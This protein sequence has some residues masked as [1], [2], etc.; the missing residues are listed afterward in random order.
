MRAPSESES[1]LG[2]LVTRTPSIQRLGLIGRLVTTTSTRT[3]LK[4]V[5]IHPLAR[6]GFTMLLI[7]LRSIPRYLP[8]RGLRGDSDPLCNGNTR[9]VL[10]GSQRFN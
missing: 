3:N 9:L 4:E 10:L 5:I 2:V 7:A 1:K 6:H 8:G